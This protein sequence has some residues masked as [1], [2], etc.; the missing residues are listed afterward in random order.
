MTTKTTQ[1]DKIKADLLSGNSVDSVTAF[2]DHYITRL[3]SVIKRLRE[4]G[5]PIVTDQDSG[6]GLAH[7]SLPEGW[8]PETL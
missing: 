1:L 5:Y 3:S 6:N 2:N 8:Q 7:Y 4:K